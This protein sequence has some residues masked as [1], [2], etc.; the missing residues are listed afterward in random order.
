MNKNRKL[1]RLSVVLFV[2]GLMVSGCH[3]GNSG[4]TS[5]TGK[6]SGVSALSGAEEGMTREIIIEGFDAKYKVTSEEL[7]FYLERVIKQNTRVGTP[8][9]K[10]A[11]Q[12]LQET[13]IAAAEL[14]EQVLK[15]PK[16]ASLVE[17]EK[18]FEAWNALSEKLAKRTGIQNMFHMDN[19][20]DL[21]YIFDK[22]SREDVQLL[23]QKISKENMAEINSINT[24]KFVSSVDDLDNLGKQRVLALYPINTQK[25]EAAEYNLIQVAKDKK[26]LVGFRPNAAR[27][28]RMVKV[29]APVPEVIPVAARGARVGTRAGNT[30]KSEYGLI[31]LGVGAVGMTG[32]YLGAALADAITNEDT[33]AINKINQ[34]FVDGY[35]RFSMWSETQDG[36]ISMT[37]IDNVSSGNM[38]A[39]YAS[40]GIFAGVALSDAS[41]MDEGIKVSQNLSGAYLMDPIVATAYNNAG[42]GA[43]IGLGVGMGIIFLNPATAPFVGMAYGGAYL[44]TLANMSGDNNYAD[45]MTKWVADVGYRFAGG[46]TGG[47]DSR[48]G[49]DARIRY[50]SYVPFTSDYAKHPY[51]LIC[52]NN[53]YDDAGS[54]DPSM[55]DTKKSLNNATFKQHVDS[56]CSYLPDGSTMSRYVP[57][58]YSSYGSTSNLF[59]VADSWVDKTKFMGYN[60]ISRKI[61]GTYDNIYRYVEVPSSSK[62]AHNL[63]FSYSMIENTTSVGGKTGND[64]FIVVP[65]IDSARF[66]LSKESNLWVANQISSNGSTVGISRFVMPIQ[67]E[68][69]V[70]DNISAGT[71]NNHYNVSESE[72]WR[73]YPLSLLVVNSLTAAKVNGSTHLKSISIESDSQFTY[74]SVGNVRYYTQSSPGSLLVPLAKNTNNEYDFDYTTLKNMMEYGTDCP[75]LTKVC[76]SDKAYQS[77]AGQPAVFNVLSSGLFKTTTETDVPS[78]VLKSR[79]TDGFGYVRLMIE[80]PAN[81][82]EHGSWGHLAAYRITVPIFWEDHKPYLFLKGNVL[83]KM[84]IEHVYYDPSK[85]SWLPDTFPTA[86]TSTYASLSYDG[87][88]GTLVFNMVDG[89]HSDLPPYF[90]ETKPASKPNIIYP[91]S[92]GVNLCSNDGYTT[93]LESTGHLSAR[94]TIGSGSYQTMGINSFTSLLN[95]ESATFPQFTVASYTD[96]IAGGKKV[97]VLAPTDKMRNNVPLGDYLTKCKYPMYL[98][99]KSDGVVKDAILSAS[100]PTSKGNRVVSLDYKQPGCDIN[101]VKSYVGYDESSNRLYCAS[102]SKISYSPFTPYLT[103]DSGAACDSID[104]S[105]WSEKGIMKAHCSY[106]S[107]TEYKSSWF[108]F[109]YGKLCAPGDLIRFEPGAM[110]LSCANPS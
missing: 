5:S 58:L 82:H 27:D 88:H 87:E 91:G 62:N 74:N 106:M 77:A 42:I 95:S 31:A 86:K 45:A 1:K 92:T 39:A 21:D 7:R 34:A 78:K 98:E 28:F 99:Y 105:E 37:Y 94:C 75:S 89:K 83:S 56:K 25:W 12:E 32:A 8:Y 41:K 76:S 57:S 38:L 2:S 70:A 68:S 43:A 100:C 20:V 85:L 23:L 107:K 61:E 60:Y 48:D 6:A 69:G 64:H 36:K 30:A 3:G 53:Q 9:V 19:L 35:N 10:F 93:V 16:T 84:P 13:Y 22:W 102:A 33:Q 104:D 97:N 17:Q 63:E 26:G 110:R 49:T 71:A 40:S 101:G 55:R 109:D 72:N 47:D 24:M 44:L 51:F 18:M 50:A 59:P 4:S 15:M 11:M 103:S 65:K 46:I 108:S 96:L 52:A 73:N 54:S 79:G 81:S 14:N 80:D 29:K 66:S 90:V 67:L